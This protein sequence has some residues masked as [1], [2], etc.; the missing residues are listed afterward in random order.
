MP[1]QKEHK[2]APVKEGELKRIPPK[3]S[4]RPKFTDEERA[5]YWREQDPKYT[6]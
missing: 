6:T 5:D 2:E 1:E 4:D 3:N